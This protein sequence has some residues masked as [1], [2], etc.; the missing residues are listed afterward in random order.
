MGRIIRVM[1]MDMVGDMD[2]AMVV[3]EEV[4]TPMAEVSRL[5]PVYHLV[6]QACRQFLVWEVTAKSLAHHLKCSIVSVN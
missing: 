4:A 3:P 5:S 2:I 1:R 6:S